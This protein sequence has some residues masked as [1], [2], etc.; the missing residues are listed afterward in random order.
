MC[1]DHLLG[2]RLHVIPLTCVSF[3]LFTSFL[4]ISVESS[5]LT[6]DEIEAYRDEHN[7][8]KVSGF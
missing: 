5:L 7:L 2:V 8:F 6:I 3:S 1:M 4:E